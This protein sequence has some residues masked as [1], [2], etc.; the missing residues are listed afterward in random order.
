M[1][2]TSS[3]PPRYTGILEWP[4]SAHLPEE[5]VPRH[6]EGK[7]EGIDAGNHDLLDEGLAEF[8]HAPYHLLPFGEAEVVPGAV[9]LGLADLKILPRLEV[10]LRGGIARVEGC[11]VASPPL[12]A[13]IATREVRPAREPRK[14]RE[15]ARAH[16]ILSAER[17]ESSSS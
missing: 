8:L 2:T 16:S 12:P 7:E 13:P 3:T 15:E 14:P 9:D 1:P 10:P 11:G 5:R 4:H 17:P 6:V